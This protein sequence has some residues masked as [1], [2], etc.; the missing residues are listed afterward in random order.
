[1]G[2]F[3]YLPTRPDICLDVYAQSVRIGSKVRIKALT[4]QGLFVECSRKLRTHYP[5]GTIFKLD[6]RL[7]SP[8]NKKP[9]LVA[10]HQN[11]LQRAVEFFDY[12]LSLQES[13]LLSH[14]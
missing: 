14:S 1:M 7:V 12:N 6:T 8:K 10:L 11:S 3:H 9:Y 5:I 13:P 4:H 2:L